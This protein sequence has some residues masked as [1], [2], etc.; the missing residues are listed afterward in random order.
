MTEEVSTGLGARSM[1]LHGQ[2]VTLHATCRAGFHIREMNTKKVPRE[3][4]VA[5]TV[6][7]VLNPAPPLQSCGIVLK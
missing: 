5:I 7:C 1:R 4:A 2:R 6:T 3:K